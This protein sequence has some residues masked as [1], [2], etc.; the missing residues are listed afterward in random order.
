MDEGRVCEPRSADELS[1]DAFSDLVGL[2]YQGPIETVPWKSFLDRIRIDL[3]ARYSTFV[4]R[5]P[6][7]KGGGLMVNSGEAVSTEMT[8]AYNETYFTLDPFLN[9]PANTVVTAEEI[10]GSQAWRSSAI[11]REYLEPLGIGNILGADLYTDEGIHCRFRVSLGAGQPDFSAA[12]RAL[13]RLMLPHLRRSVSLHSRLDA[14][15]SERRL[16][17]GTMDRL[18][19]GTVILDENGNVLRMNRIAEDIL[20]ERDGLRLSGSTLAAETG[21]ENK[22]LKRLINETLGRSAS[23]SVSMVE[24]LSITRPSGRGK[25]G[26]LIRN[27]PLAEWSEGKRYP[28]AALFIRDPE[29]RG[30]A[31]YERIVRQLFDLTPAETALALLLANGLSLDEAAEQLNIRRNTARAHLRMIFSKTGVTRQTEL[32]RTI[33]NSV[34]SLI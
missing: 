2:C 5:N 29:R 24:A 23:P 1:L 3:N 20:S 11:F 21:Q 9:L 8:E 25:L 33:L 4:L 31:S 16:Y 27:V 10:V 18:L 6:T 15:E 30:Q 7:D 22:E 13:C 17:V 12:D 32:V 28:A 34:V 14:L 19:I 26:I